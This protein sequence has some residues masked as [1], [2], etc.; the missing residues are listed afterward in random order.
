MSPD[1]SVHTQNRVETGDMLEP[2]AII[3]HDIK[4]PQDATS[5]ESF[6]QMLMDRK[7]AMTEI[8]PERFNID[9]FYCSGETG[10]G[11]VGYSQCCQILY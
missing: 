3:G 1:H 4:F 10:N 2:I 11:R 6:W 8:P 5:P 7:S 9:A